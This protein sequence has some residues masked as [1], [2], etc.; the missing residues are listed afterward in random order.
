MSVDYD[1]VIIGST[2]VGIDAAMQAARYKARVALIEQNCRPRFQWHQAFS[3]IGQTLHQIERSNQFKFFE[4]PL[5]SGTVT[6]EHVRQWVN[7]IAQS[8]RE[9]YAPEKLAA[10]G[11]EFV[12]GSG[13]FCRNPQAGFR[14]DG[15]VFRSRAY[16]IATDY[17][18]TIP[19]IPGLC[20][21]PYLTPEVIPTEVPRSLVIMGDDAS[22]VELAQLY[23]QLGS[24]VTIVLRQPTVLSIADPEVAFWVQAQLE[25]EG[26][27]I[28]TALHI[29]EIL[30]TQKKKQIRAGDFSIEADEILV[31]TG[32][33]RRINGLNL[34]AMGVLEPIQLNEKLQTRNPHVYWCSHPV[35]AIAQCQAYLSVRNALFL[36]VLNFNH[37]CVVQSIATHPELAWV[38]LTEPQAIRQY[39]KSALVLRQPFNSLLKAQITGDITGLC[40][41]IVHRDGQ[42]IG[43]HIVGPNASELI[44]VIALA[45]RQNIKIQK[46]DRLPE[47]SDNF[48]AVFR[49]AA[50]EWST[51]RITQ[52]P[53][54]QDLQE[55]YFAWQRSRSINITKVRRR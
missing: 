25:A 46:F 17:T 9:F 50:H 53:F 42:I 4:P 55:S 7:A 49:N 35:S 37:H 23:S 52:K 32:W 27:R 3:N 24:Q 44:S 6:L 16:L 51:W 14:V 47:M 33:Q 31:A 54:L 43:A 36:P 29:T 2:I 34:E 8:Q 45:M 10:S 38:G 26:I 20:D 15:R 12:V 40:K 41:I 11:I 1:L 48:T 5:E 30:Q 39:R 28:I 21:V 18:P 19:E 22:G 13:E